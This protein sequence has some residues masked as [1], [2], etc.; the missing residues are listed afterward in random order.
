MIAG[1]IG[2][3][4]LR[5]IPGPLLHGLA[6]GEYRLFGST[7]RQ[8]ANGRIVGFLQEA[9]PRAL[10]SGN[11]VLAPVSIAADLGQ[12]VQG[13][14]IRAGVKRLEAGMAVLQTL[15]AANLAV[16]AAGLGVSL[17][18]F[19]VMSARIEAVR[20]AVSALSD[21][22]ADVGRKIDQI[23]Q[24][25]VDLEFVE[26]QA[27][28]RSADEA[29]RLSDAAAESRWREV[30]RAA[31]HHQARF[32][33]RADRMLA[34]DARRYALADPFLDALALTAALR[35]SALIASNES[36]A[37]REAAADG[38]RSLERLTGGLGLAD[39][40]RI[41]QR[42]SDAPPGTRQWALAQTCAN[43][44]VRDT[45]RKMRQREAAALTRA[46]PLADL[47]Q[48]GVTPR[49]WLAQVRAETEAPVLV[50]L[51]DR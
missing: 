10:Q 11:P 12:L 27:L 49:D 9:A 39:L 23:Q 34:G 17:V 35:V 8:A 40:S 7:I 47:A 14:L 26:I 32:E 41:E 38:A 19:A 1:A 5:E 6:S 30:A 33:L 51:A 50:M 24:D 20:Q 22:I 16:S 28:A 48:R 18:G 4:L 42:K 45:V 3:L 44:A 43:E 37:A 2:G 46:A 21:Q 29:W 31:L 13:E 15:G 36:Q 25:A